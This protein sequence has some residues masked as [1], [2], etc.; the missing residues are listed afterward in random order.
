MGDDDFTPHPITVDVEAARAS[1]YEEGRKSG[2]QE[3]KYEGFREG[4]SE[5]VGD[6]LERLKV[7]EIFNHEEHAGCLVEVERVAG[8]M[9]V[10]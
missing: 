6:L 5:G 3:G 7:L 1:A 2:L 9:K 4:Y 10:P 8:G